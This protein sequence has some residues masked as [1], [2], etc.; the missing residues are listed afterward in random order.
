M[1]EIS[2]NLS[3]INMRYTKEDCIRA[4]QEFYS[5]TGSL[6][7]E[8]YIHSKRKPSVSTIV[9]LY[10]SWNEAKVHSGY[11]KS[12]K[13]RY[14]KEDCIRAIQEFYSETGSPSINN[15]IRSKKKPSIDSIK[16]IFGTW[17]KAKLHAGCSD[18][19]RYTK[20]DCIRALQEFKLETG[21]VSFDKYSETKKKP[22]ADFIKKIFGTWEEAKLHAGCSEYKRYTKEDCIRA[23]QEFQLEMGK[24]SFDKYRESK[25]KPSADSIKRIFGT[26]EEAKIHSG[27][28]VNKK[29]T[30]EDAIKSLQSFV[31]GNGNLIN[32]TL[33]SESKCEPKVGKIIKFFGSWKKALIAAGL[34]DS[35]NKNTKEDCIKAIQE[36]YNE[37][38]MSGSVEYSLSLR[39]PSVGTIINRFGSWNSAL[40]EAG[41]PLSRRPNLRGLTESQ[42]RESCIKSL[43][44]LKEEHG[45]TTLRKYIDANYY[46][47][48]S[49][50]IRVFGTWNDAL[51][52]AGLIVKVEKNRSG[53]HD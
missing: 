26:W 7:I 18:Y 1:K 46:P 21:N 38:G 17:K 28:P 48:S 35:L 24:V 14:T 37:T 47:P 25:K 53:F 13:Q 31:K 15:Y 19:K 27:L 43:I 23:L 45:T 44:K 36:Y 30:K 50:I 6:S 20:E 52:A 29:Y 11:S 40:V 16:R 32:M 49:R 3:V 51:V 33:Y 22:S 41:I 2:E 10:G 8:K 39:K 5:E 4:I 9:S 42:I 12:E 34:G